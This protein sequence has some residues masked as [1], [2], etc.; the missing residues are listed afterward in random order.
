MSTDRIC[1]LETGTLRGN[2][3][4]EEETRYRKLVIRMGVLLSL[5]VTL[6][7]AAFYSSQ[8]WWGPVIFLV[9]IC[10]G[11]LVIHRIS[12][13][14]YGKL[15]AALFF[16]IAII[17][18]YGIPNL[19]L[20]RESGIHYFLLC[21]SPFLFIT[22]P[23]KKDFTFIILIGFTSLLAF[24]FTEYSSLEPPFRVEASSGT[25]TLLHLSSTT[26]MIFLISSLVL[27]LYLDMNKAKNALEK[28]H[29]RS[30]ALLL[31]IL[32]AAIA[33]RLKASTDVIAETFTEASVLFA[34]IAGFTEFAGKLSP[35]ALV[36]ILN[37][38]F[39]AYDELAEKYAV[40][41][42]KTIGD[43]YM[44]AAG[45]PEARDDHAEALVRMG[46]DMLA[47]TREINRELGLA[48]DIRIGVNSGSVTAGV[49]GKKKFIYDLWGDTVNIA[50][51]ME[52]H[53]VPGRVQ[54]AGWTYNLLKQ[55]LPF[56]HRGRMA[57]KGKG[58]LD[59]YLLK[60]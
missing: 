29:R 44:V 54:V 56:E 58:E 31:N 49:I 12:E 1:R 32:P 33:A 7:Y 14:I 5:L 23:Q 50:S 24:L 4:P 36:T 25:L 39:S 17:M 20:G 28:E 52:S 45:I 37:R 40:E 19:F 26:G 18:L 2:V 48:F 34:D 47:V 57:I 35:G 27:I 10:I 8:G 43:A 42:I 59:V 38:Y 55:K 60:T 41:K 30:E 3:L 46:C 53:G 6:G 16:I 21:I 51:R 22:F 9:P 11:L 15:L 13:N